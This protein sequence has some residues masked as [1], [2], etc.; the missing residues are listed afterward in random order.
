MATI[1]N[2]IHGAF[3]GKVGKVVGYVRRGQAIMRTQGER[4]TKPTAKELLNREKFAISQKWLSPLTDFLR[5]GFKDYHPNYEGFVAAK[6]YNHK[7]ALQCNED[8]NFFINPVLAL[9]SFGSQELP[10]TASAVTNESQE[11]IFTWSTEGVHEYNDNAMVVVYDIENEKIIYN[12]G[13]AR[14]HTG[15][16]T[17]KLEQ[18]QIG[19]TFHVYLAFIT[20]DRTS[21]SNSM[22]LGSLVIS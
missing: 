17:L 20:D 11:I 13:I 10:L 6:S 3:S 14:R 22:Y 21:K 9:V 2:G 8:N 7:H 16:A 18:T 1:N 5:I 4:T 12:P 19:N 15:T